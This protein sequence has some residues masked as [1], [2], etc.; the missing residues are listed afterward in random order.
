MK[1][2]TL[3]RPIADTADTAKTHVRTMSADSARPRGHGAHISNIWAVSRVR[4]HTGTII[5]PTVET[6]AGLYTAAI[7]KQDPTGWCV[8]RI[9][10]LIAR[11]G[12]TQSDVES[13]IAN[14]GPAA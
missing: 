9:R 1:S 7:Q 13:F 4:G 12:L 6:F 11:H 3:V 10:T 5:K 2:R 14:N 8:Q